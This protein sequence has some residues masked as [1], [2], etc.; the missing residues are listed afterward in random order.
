MQRAIRVAGM[1]V[2]VLAAFLAAAAPRQAGAA[3]FTQQAMQGAAAAVFARFDPA[4]GRLDAVRLTV[5]ERYASEWRSQ[6]LFNPTL[7]KT[8]RMSWPARS[9]VVSGLAGV[10]A[11]IAFDQS[12]DI[13]AVVLPPGWGWCVHTQQTFK[14]FTERCVPRADFQG[15]DLDDAV[16]SQELA[17]ATILSLP[18]APFT[19]MAGDTISVLL[20]SGSAPACG[21]AYPGAPDSRDRCTRGEAAISFTLVYDYTAAADLRPNAVPAPGGAGLLLGGLALVGLL[22]ARRG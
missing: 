20:P 11:D 8:F 3:L 12:V 2:L 19:G 22:R 14:L 17:Q 9:L 6:S 4:L 10:A 15:L 18:A 13:A 1:G 16:F 7:P 21:F 5:E